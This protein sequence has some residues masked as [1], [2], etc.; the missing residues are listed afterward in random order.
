MIRR[1]MSRGICVGRMLDVGGRMMRSYVS[2]Y[3]TRVVVV[4]SVVPNGHESHVL[5]LGV[6]AEALDQ[7]RSCLH[8]RMGFGLDVA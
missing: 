3:I 4:N 6:V 7:N 8:H 5:L 1:T 2:I